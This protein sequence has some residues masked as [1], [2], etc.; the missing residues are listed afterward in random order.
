MSKRK[1]AIEKNYVQVK[2]RIKEFRAKHEDYGLH[3]EILSITKDEVLMKAWITNADERIVAVGHSR[4]R[5]SDNPN[6]N[7]ISLVE[8][9]ETSAWGRAL[10]NLGFGIEK[11]IASAEEMRKAKPS[12]PVKYTGTNAQKGKLQRA[13]RAA[14]IEAP[15]VAQRIHKQLIAKG[16][17]DDAL[18]IT[19]FIEEFQP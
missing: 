3:S 10:A 1:E 18:S 7:I 6:I 17:N 19:K 5:T 15:E 13:L 14:N 12:E 11:S 16:I 4:E 8:N 2:D 9:G